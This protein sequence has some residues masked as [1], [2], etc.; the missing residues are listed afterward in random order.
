MSEG[1]K[2]KP[3]EYQKKYQETKKILNIMMNKIVF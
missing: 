1:K 2:Q 3:K